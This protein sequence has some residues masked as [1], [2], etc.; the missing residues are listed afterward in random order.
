M[1]AAVRGAVA[2][3]PARFFNRE[4]HVSK[5]L[6]KEYRTRYP[7]CQYTMALLEAGGTKLAG[8]PYKWANRKKPCKPVLQLD[9]IYGRRGPSEVWSNY[10]MSCSIVHEWKTNH[11]ALGRIVATWWKLRMHL[12]GRSSIDR[13][14]F[15]LD[16]MR[17]VYGKNPVAMCEYWNE[18]MD[19]PGWA[20]QMVMDTVESVELAN[21]VRI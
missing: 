21:T 15:D 19:I 17:A 2:P 9:H 18:T 5:A 14:H 1:H 8:V 3:V 20:S 11:S 16:A 13:R 10:M 4:S 7:H 12:M 6:M